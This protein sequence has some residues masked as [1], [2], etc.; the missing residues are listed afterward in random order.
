[1][2]ADSLRPSTRN[3]RLH[4]KHQVR[5]IAASLKAF[6]FTNPILLDNTG[7]IIAGHGRLEA[8]KL[9]GITEVPTILLENLTPNQIRAYAIADNK[10]AENAGWDKSI[11]AIELQQLLT[12]SEEFDVT[13]TGFEV[14]EIDLIVQEG[15]EVDPADTLD[16]TQEGPA[17]C[18]PGELWQLGSHR[19]LCGSALEEASFASLMGPRKAQMAFLDPPYNVV[20][21]GNVSGKGAVKHANFAMASG[22]MS[23][24][25]FTQFLS[26]SLGLVA[27]HSVPGSV[28]FVCLDWRHLN[29]ILEAGEK[30]YDSLL[31]LCVWVKDNGGQGSF[32]RSRHELVF[33]FRHGKASHRNNIQLGKFGRYRT[34]V[35]EYPAVRG[36]AQQHTEEGNLL[37]LHPTVK[38]VALVSDAILDCS[39]RG[40]LILDSFL[41]SGSTLISAERTGRICYGIEL[42]PRYVDIAVRRW[43]QHTGQQAIH[44]A[45]GLG[46]GEI[47]TKDRRI[48]G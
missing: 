15:A 11:L 26:Q 5:Q 40:D 35:W 3:A 20:I 1:M 27:R 32:Y 21:D 10:L 12:I 37:A 2:A 48:N 46:F 33:V 43:Q 14:S 25:E 7:T 8:A 29:E 45:S 18:Q 30:A 4:T 6:G 19:I 39:A 41:G 24:A 34:N 47:S 38:P 44:A 36:L 9:L 13:I 42:D 23:R 31:N 17:V 22:E 28:H 16:G